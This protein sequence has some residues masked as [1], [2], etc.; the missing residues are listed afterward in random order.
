VGPFRTP[1]EAEAARAKLKELGV[2][3]AQAITLK[4]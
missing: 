4:Q 3:G 2:Y 1:E